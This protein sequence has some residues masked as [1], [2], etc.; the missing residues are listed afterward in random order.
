[1]A[2]ARLA[3]LGEVLGDREIARHADLLAARHAHAVDAADD[4]LVAAQDR[5][6]HVVEQAH[7]LPVLLGAPGVVGGVLLGVAAGA[8]GALAGAGEDHRDA[9]AVVR[10][11]P[12]AEDHA[13]DHPGGV[14]IVL[15]RVVERDARD[16]EA[17]HHRAPASRSGATS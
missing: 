17:G 3:E 14:G 4:R 8:E 2:G 11:A 5:A 9:G 13:L 10:G 1:V 6:H 12:E 16:V 15:A 7:V